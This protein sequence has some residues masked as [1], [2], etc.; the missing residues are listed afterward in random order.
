MKRFFFI[1]FPLLFLRCDL[2]DSR[3]AEK[4]GTSGSKFQP[5]T[6]ADIL[7]KNLMFSFQDKNTENYIA[8]LSDTTFTGKKFF[9]SPSS[10]AIS[11]FPEL[12]QNWELDDERLYFENAKSKLKEGELITLDL[13]NISFTP[14]GND[15]IFYSAS[16][17][18]SLPN[19]DT[20]LPDE[21]QGDLSFKMIQDRQSVIWYI[22]NWQDIKSTSLPSWSELKGRLH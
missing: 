2:F 19:D 21:Y 18:L 16:Y 10:G 5:A 4:P 20:N 8:C 15:S 6:S 1:A 7:I 22:Y 3:D 13:Y 11:Q 14:Q 17:T 9:F 12:A